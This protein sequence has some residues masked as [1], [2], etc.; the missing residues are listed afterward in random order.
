VYIIHGLARWACRIESM[1]I[2]NDTIS[3]QL[4][5]GSPL[6]LTYVCGARLKFTAL[7]ISHFHCSASIKPPSAT[8]STVAQ[9]IKLGRFALGL[10]FLQTGGLDKFVFL[11]SEAQLLF[12][13]HASHSTFSEEHRSL[14]KATHASCIE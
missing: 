6:K 2:I 5:G 3:L 4:H 9:R 11:N 14:A 7:S 13:E 12:T 1:Y 8:N 10:Q